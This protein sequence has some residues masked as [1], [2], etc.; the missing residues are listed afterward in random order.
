MTLTGD[1]NEP[2]LHQI[3][4]IQYAHGWYFF[5]HDLPSILPQGHTHWH[6]VTWRQIYPKE[7]NLF[8]SFRKQPQDDHDLAWPIIIII[9]ND[10]TEYS[11]IQAPSRSTWD[12]SIQS[13]AAK[14]RIRVD[15]LAYIRISF[16][17][18]HKL[19]A[20]SREWHKEWGKFSFEIRRPGYVVPFEVGIF[21]RI[22]LWD[23]VY[24]AVIHGLLRMPRVVAATSNFTAPSI[25]QLQPYDQYP[26][27]ILGR[28][29][30]LR[31]LVELGPCAFRQSYP[32]HP[33]WFHAKSVD[34][35]LRLY[36]VFR[37]HPYNWFMDI[38][39]MAAIYI[40]LLNIL[41]SLKQQNYFHS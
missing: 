37:N 25:K 9:I 32:M 22:I 35:I 15:N 23:A 20:P 3:R 39:L 41:M 17:T 26:R 2:W 34:Y 18:L 10:E 14:S 8:P 27:T 38:S 40:I 30:W 24:R 21:L 11:W 13:T 1:W 31:L 7:K 28:L 16:T 12:T 19:S 29:L 6:I 33:W 5:Q 4:G 36:I